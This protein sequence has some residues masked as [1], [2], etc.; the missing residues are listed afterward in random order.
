MTSAIEKTST[1][2]TDPRDERFPRGLR[3]TWE[4]ELLISGAVVFALLQLPSALHN[5][6]DRLDPHLDGTA[7]IGL[8]IVYAYMTLALYTLIGSFLLHLGA[9]AYWVGLVGLEAVFPR[10][11]QWDRAQYGPFTRRF[12][13]ERAPSLQALIAKA[14]DFCSTIF[15]FSFTIVFSFI[16]STLWAGLL[17]LVAFLISRFFFGGERLGS[18][19]MTL[20]YLL[21]IPMLVVPILDRAIGNKLSPTG[22]PARLL[23]GLTG[24]YHRAFLMNLYS[25]VTNILLTNVPKK[26]IYPVFFASFAVL[27]GAFFLATFIRRGQLSLDSGIYLPAE[28][29][30]HEVSSVFYE[31][32]RPEG[33]IFRAP[34]IQSDVIRD[35]YVKLF[36]PYY[37]RRHN[38]LIEKRCPDVRPLREGGLRLELPGEDHRPQGSPEAVLRCLAGIHK[39]ALDG[40]PLA[41]SSFHF[42]THPKTGL[43]GIVTY[44]PTAG[45]SRG[46]HL[47]RVA[48]V[49]RAEPRKGEPP[50]D[51]YLIRFWL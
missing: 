4:L 12:Y 10:G 43:R 14:D 51:P 30:E 13:E 2:E 38:P 44:I 9:R 27:M 1:G 7:R 50:P 42:Y 18:I 15:S 49:P 24:F 22:W 21:L 11:I 25:P 35:P 47:L 26:V 45:L 23:L 16:A 8:L 40:K 41:G 3:Q 37:A 36:I 6:F 31:S 32:L 29:G 28:P 48:A 20:A 5:A 46:S 19:F 39:V 34:S 17:G 33:K